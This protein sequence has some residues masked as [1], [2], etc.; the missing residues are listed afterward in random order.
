VDLPT[1]SGAA[2]LD[3]Q[4]Q[5]SVRL[6]TARDRDVERVGPFVATFDPHTD[7]PYLSY[8]IPDDGARPQPGDVAALAAAFRRRGRRPRLE[9]LPAVAPAVEAALLAGGF[10]LEARLA[11]MTC[12][13]GDAEAVPAPPGIAVAAPATDADLLGL[14]RAQRAAFGVGDEP[15]SD[16]DAQA[17][18]EVARRRAALAAGG[19]ALV[20]RD[21]TTGAIVGGGVTTVPAGGVSELAGIGVLASHRRRGIAAAL[22]AGL[23]RAAFAAG[24]QLVWLTP[25]DDGAHRVYARAGFADRIEMVH[26]SMDG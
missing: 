2:A 20:A 17:A 24:Q 16:D 14:S 6:T 21:E 8:A 25:G 26:I 4:L 22:T 23:A 10:A 12:V 13:P 11:V 1:P 18:D 3:H 9:Y 15:A 7:H 19:L 5:Q